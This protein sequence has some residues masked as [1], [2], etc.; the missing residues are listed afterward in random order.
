MKYDR[1]ILLIS[2]SVEVD[3]GAVGISGAALG[4]RIGAFFP[5]LVAEFYPAKRADDAD[6]RAA[7]RARVAFG[8]ALLVPAGPAN[9]RIAFTEDLAHISICSRSGG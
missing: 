5:A 6:E 9:H 3:Q 4:R 1:E 7:I 8:R 2:I